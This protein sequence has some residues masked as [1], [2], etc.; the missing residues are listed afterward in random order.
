MKDY[1]TE[2]QKWLTD[3][4]TLR[5]TSKAKLARWAFEEWIDHH[6]SQLPPHIID[7]FWEWKRGKDVL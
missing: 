1:E 4:S 2:F 3:V 7:W 6:I 5:G